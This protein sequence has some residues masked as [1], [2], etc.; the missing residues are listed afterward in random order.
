MMEPRGTGETNHWQAVHVLASGP[1]SFEQINVLWR[2]SMLCRQQQSSH[3]QQLS[4][5]QK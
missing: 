2:G 4:S 1:K 5:G 3:M